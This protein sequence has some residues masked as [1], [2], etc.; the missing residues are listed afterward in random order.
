MALARDWEVT[1]FNRGM[2][3]RGLVPGA[4]ELVGDRKGD[5]AVLGNGPWDAV[6][7]TCGYLPAEVACMAAALHG[8]VEMYVFISSVSVY[9]GFTTPNNEH[10]AVGH[11]ADGDTQ[12][13]EPHTYGPLKALCEAQV[14]ACFGVKHSLIVRPGLIVGPCDFTQRFTYW[15]ARLSRAQDG[16]PVLA[17]G[18]PTDRLQFIDVRDLVNFVLD[19]VAR[20]Q[21]G[22]FNV[23]S[24]PQH[25]SM[26][27]LLDTCAAVAKCTPHWVWAN[28]DQAEELQL[29]A[30]TDLPV[31]VPA[32]GEHAAFGL[33]D[34]SAAVA[35]GLTFRPLHETVHDTLRWWQSLPPL[36]Q[37]FSKAGLTPEREAAAIAALTH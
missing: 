37:A 13:V 27:T 9:A 24:P 4:V 10:S 7:D 12:T 25:H 23:T 29:S 22:T 5:L 6:I 36:Q 26:G 30:W 31:W 34:V 20:Q 19:C 1:L 14:L 16:E 28:A 21:A 8:R 11:I 18:S 35:A 15:P 2:T 33:T 17:P 3:G 32:R